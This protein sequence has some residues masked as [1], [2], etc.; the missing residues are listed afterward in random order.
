MFLLF[1]S[2]KSERAILKLIKKKLIFIRFYII[3]NL[4]FDDIIR[5][6]QE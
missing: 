6:K 4:K 3:F 1:S 5:M 2:F